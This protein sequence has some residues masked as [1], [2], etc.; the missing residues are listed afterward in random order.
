MIYYFDVFLIC[1]VAAV[2]RDGGGVWLLVVG[3]LG[4]SNEH[5]N[6]NTLNY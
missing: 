6:S 3:G 4:S 1:K 2:M 5:S